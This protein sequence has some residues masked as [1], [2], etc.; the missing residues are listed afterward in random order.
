MCKAMKPTVIN[1][2]S[3]QEAVCYG[4]ETQ[5]ETGDLNQV[6]HKVE[7]IIEKS[8]CM[9]VSVLWRQEGDGLRWG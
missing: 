8:V 9:C 2:C 5:M 4:S 6:T 1:S 3:R 7:E